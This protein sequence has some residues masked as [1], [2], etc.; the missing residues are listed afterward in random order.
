M[1]PMMGLLVFTE[2]HPAQPASAVLPHLAVLV[3]VGNDATNRQQGSVN[4][5]D[6]EIV[7]R[8]VGWLDL[9]VQRAKRL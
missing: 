9:N 4:R 5:K 3:L 2:L 1:G 6:T 7:H 8:H